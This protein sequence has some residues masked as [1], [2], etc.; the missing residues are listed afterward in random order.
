M[1]HSYAMSEPCQSSAWRAATYGK[2]VSTLHQSE[3]FTL[4]ERPHII[5]EKEPKE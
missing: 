1:F 3:D 4:W 5:S 2:H